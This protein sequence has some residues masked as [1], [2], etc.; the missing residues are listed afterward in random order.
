[1][2]QFQHRV[3][4]QKRILAVVE[5]PSHFVKVGREVLGADPVPRSHNPALQERERRVTHAVHMPF[6]LPYMY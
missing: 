4:E 5:P 2:N 6:A 3:T 1:M